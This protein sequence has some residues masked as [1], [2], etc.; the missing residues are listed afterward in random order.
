MKPIY[1]HF[2]FG[3]DWNPEQWPEETWEHDIEMLEDAHINE[4]TI[5]V[6]SWA[7]LQPAEDRYDFTMLDKIVALLVKHDFNIVMATGTAALPGWMV[8]LHPEVIR[9]EQNGTRHVR[10]PTQLLPDLAVLPRSVPR[11]RRT[12]GRTLHRHSGSG[13][14]A[15]VQRIRRR[16]RPVLLRPVCGILP[17]MAQGQVWHRRSAQPG[18]VRQLLEPHHHRMGRRG[19]TR[20]LWRWHRRRQMRGLRPADGLSS[21]PKPGTARML[22][23]RT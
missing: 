13:E 20:Q 18:V 9:T 22:Q 14:L 23:E 8:R 11:A 15:C 3:G 10:R 7:L 12:C 6:F 4:V 2:L 16:R 21:L 19:A 17:R 5:N 1:N